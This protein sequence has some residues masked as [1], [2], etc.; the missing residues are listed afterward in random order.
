MQRIEHK[1]VVTSVEGNKVFVTIISHSACE[2]CHAK[3]ICSGGGTS[4]SKAKVIEVTV[5]DSSNYK[6][7][8]EV[9]LFITTSTGIKVVVMAYVIPVIICL[10]A[11]VFMNR[12]GISD[13][14]NGLI[15]LV[16]LV[17]YFIILFTFRRKITNKILIEIEKTEPK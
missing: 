13:N 9:M 1:G 6:I 5:P 14:V 4:E 15:S 8:D 12:A 2:A 7:S 10:L 16:F 17:L 11:L 3:G